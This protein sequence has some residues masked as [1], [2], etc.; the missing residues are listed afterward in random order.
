MRDVRVAKLDQGDPEVFIAVDTSMRQLV[1]FHE[2][3]TIIWQND[4]GGGANAITLLRDQVVCATNSGYVL[5]FD[6]T[7]RRRWSYFLGEAA[8]FLAVRGQT[9]QA[10]SDHEVFNLDSSGKPLGK[11]AL[12]AALSAAPRAG[13]QRVGG[14]LLLGL[15]DGRILEQ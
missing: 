5:A 7:G 8:Q 6:G 3:G 4:V 13:D 11:T 12:P 9:I 2:D 1:A 14:R 15:A 10:V